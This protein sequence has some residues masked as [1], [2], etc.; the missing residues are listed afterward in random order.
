VQALIPLI[1]ANG[2]ALV[3]GADNGVLSDVIKELG[4][5]LQ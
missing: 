3:S 4:F 2:V 5:L 1:G